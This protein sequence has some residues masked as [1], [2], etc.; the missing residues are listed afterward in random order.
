MED[1]E[2]I[3]YLNNSSLRSERIFRDRYS[4][5]ESFNDIDF[6]E[7]YHLRKSR[8]YFLLGPIH[9]SP[10]PATVASARILMTMEFSKSM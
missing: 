8:Y 9:T 5:L 7:P 10:A 3:E 6:I 1:L 4:P 2:L